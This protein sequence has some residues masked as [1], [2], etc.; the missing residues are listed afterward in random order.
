MNI[1]NTQ[2][3]TPLSYSTSHGIRE[4]VIVLQEAGAHRSTIE[5]VD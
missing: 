3:D 5:D 4:F 1:M 2:G